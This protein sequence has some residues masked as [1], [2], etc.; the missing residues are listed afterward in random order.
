MQISNS[1][2]RALYPLQ[3]EQLRERYAQP[4]Q[5]LPRSPQAE[6]IERPVEEIERAEQIF[7]R[8]RSRELL[9]RAPEDP[10]IRRALDEY[11]SVQQSQQRAYLKDVLGVDEYA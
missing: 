10:R 3:L 8:N 9:A 5:P 1:S 7:I 4:D 2:I 11:E 6:P